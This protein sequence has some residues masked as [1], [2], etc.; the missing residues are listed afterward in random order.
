MASYFFFVILWNLSSISVCPTC[1]PSLRL[2]CLA[3]SV[4]IPLYSSSYRLRSLCSISPI[5][6]V[7]VFY[8]SHFRCETY[9]IANV[10]SLS[11]LEAVVGKAREIL[12]KCTFYV[13]QSPNHFHGF[14]WLTFTVC[15]CFWNKHGR[16]SMNLE[17]TELSPLQLCSCLF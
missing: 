4:C 8:I 3:T 11:E 2:R 12:R 7:I 14:I 10:P 16:I 15:S 1:P 5:D 9:F 17:H 6:R 13:F